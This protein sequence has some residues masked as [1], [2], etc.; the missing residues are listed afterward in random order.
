M[1][2]YLRRKEPVLAE[3]CVR[4]QAFCL[5]KRGYARITTTCGEE[6]NHPP[7]VGILCYPHRLAVVFAG[8]P[9]RGQ[10]I[11]RR[12]VAHRYKVRCP[13]CGR[14]KRVLYLR[15]NSREFVCRKCAGVEYSKRPRKDEELVELAELLRLLQAGGNDE[16]VNALEKV[17]I[18]EEALHKARSAAKGRS[19]QE[20]EQALWAA[21]MIMLQTV[22]EAAESGDER[23]AHL[24]DKLT[25]LL[26]P[27]LFVENGSGSGS[28]SGSKVGSYDKN[29]GKERSR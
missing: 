29:K 28:K 23:A 26:W 17:I 9:P 11:E 21:A 20:F 2:E 18:F 13:R 16:E 4:L 7:A 8:N 19:G 12:R 27:G 1:S 10:S 5:P 3:R 24:R 14:W 6:E 22:G 25:A 15:P